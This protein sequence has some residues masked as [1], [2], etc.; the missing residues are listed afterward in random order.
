MKDAWSE[1]KGLTLGVGLKIHGP[2]VGQG[3]PRVQMSLWPATPD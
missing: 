2:L 3:H 1:L